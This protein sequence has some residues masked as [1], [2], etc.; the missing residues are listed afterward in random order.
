M[1]IVIPAAVEGLR[2]ANLAGQVGQRKNAAARVAA[3][4]MDEWIANSQTRGTTRRGVVTEDAF[5]YRWILRTE[6]WTLDTLTLV[7]AEVFYTVQG[8]DYDVRLSTLVD[9]STR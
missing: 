8:R 7:T 6:P 3:R 5:E 4:V 9:V 1:A 2:I